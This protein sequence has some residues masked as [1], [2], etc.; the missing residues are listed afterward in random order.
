VAQGESGLMAVTG[1]I[2][3]QPVPV[4][5]PLCD[6]MAGTCGCAAILAAL[7][8][9]DKTGKGQRID[10]SLFEAAITMLANVA[11]NYLISGD[12]A[13]RYGTGHANIVPYQSFA[14]RNGH[15]VIACGNTTLYTK[16]CKELGCPEL[17]DD[18]RFCTNP[19]RD[20]NRTELVSLLQEKFLARDTEAWLEA[21]RVAGLPCTHIRKVSEALQDPQLV[22]RNRIWE[23]DHPTAG[24]ISLFGS[25]L[26]LSETPTRLYEAPPLL[27]EDREEILASL[28]CPPSSNGTSLLEVEVGSLVSSGDGVVLETE[29]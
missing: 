21:F 22:A 8:V 5:T 9:R 29:K 14:T 4:G 23:C 27:D 12:E 20:Q 19:L 16:L 2:D 6:V 28:S 11:S 25:P 24:K 26:H 10:I 15:I 7:R 1:E 3:G 18:P 13:P 17:I